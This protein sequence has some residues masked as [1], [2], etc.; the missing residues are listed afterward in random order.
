MTVGVYGIVAILVKLDDIALHLMK[1]STENKLGRFRV[2]FGQALLVFATN[3]MSF[4]SFF[5]MIACLLI[6]GEIISHLFPLI[7]EFYKSLSLNEIIAL[8]ISVATSLI[9]G[10]VVGVSIKLSIY[11]K[12]LLFHP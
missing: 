8:F 6:G 1:Q 11:V 2:W 7:G 4:L 5:G 10:I 12:Q 9:I 3:L